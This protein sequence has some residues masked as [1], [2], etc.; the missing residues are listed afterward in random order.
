VPRAAHHWA[1]L[2]AG[3]AL[4]VYAV[5][6][7]WNATMAGHSVA[8]SHEIAEAATDP[9]GAGYWAGSLRG[10]VGDLC[11]GTSTLLS[12]ESTPAASFFYRVQGSW[13]QASCACSGAA[14]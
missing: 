11:V 1:Y 10:E 9:D 3:G 14:E 7:A 2:G 13:S 4:R 8:A 12:D 5:I 6:E